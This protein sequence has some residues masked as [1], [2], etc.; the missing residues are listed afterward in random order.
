MSFVSTQTSTSRVGRY[1]GRAL[2]LTLA[3]GALATTQLTGTAYAA[4][5]VSGAQ[6]AGD[7]LFPNQGNGGYDV[8]HY[9]IKLKADFVTATANAAV[10]TSTVAT[11]TTIDAATT[12]APLSSYSLDFQGSTG[13][14]AASTYDVDT[15]TVNGAPAT[16]TRIEASSTT[17]ATADNHKL[18]ITPATPVEGS[19]TTVV[20]AHGAP[21][22]HFDTDGSAEGWNNTT[23]GATFVNQP[24]GS[25]TLFP[26]NNTPRDKATYTVSVDVPSTLKTSNYANAGGKPYPSAVAGNGELVSKT[27]NDDGSRT[28]WVWNE[29]KQMA[30]ELSMISIGRYDVYESDITLA[31]GRV[32]HEWSFI[33]PAIS[34]ANQNT[35]QVSRSQFKSLLD[36]YESKYGPYPGNS[37]GVV[38]D[39]VPSTINYALETQDRP[40]FPNSAGG[41][42][43]HEIMHQWWGDNVSP[44]DWNDITLNEGPA[45]YAP[46]QFAF[47]SSGTSNTT[48]EQ[49]VYATWNSAS[50]TSSTFTIAGAAMTNGNQLFGQQVYAKGAMSLE[51]LRTAIG[52]ADFETL[53]R[54]Y[55]LTYGGGQISGRRTAAFEALAESISGRDLTAF[56]QSWWFS[57]T[58][59]AWQVKFNLNVAGPTTQVNPG[60]ALTY[61]LSARNTGK[62]AMPAGGTV[63]T[64]DVGDVLDD[65]TIG[66]L[67]ANV[68]LDGSTLTWSVPATALAAT[69]TVD[70]PFTA[71]AA[72][73]GKTLK[74]VARASTLGG[75]CLSCTATTVVG[76]A[77]ISPAPVPTI[78]GGTPTVGVPLTA[79]TTGWADGTTFGYQWFLDGTPVPGATSATY[80]PASD[81]VGLPVTVRVTGTLAGFNPTTQTSAATAV[82]VRATMTTGTPTISGTPKIGQRLTVDRGTWQAGTVFTYQWRANGTNISGATGPSYV[83]AVASQVGQTIDVVVTGTRAGYT[84]ASKTSAA[85]TAVAAG[86]ALASTPT[87]TFTG[88]PKVGVP[89]APNYGSWDDGVTT[90][91]TWQANGTNIGGATTGSFTPTATQLGQTLTVTVTGTKAGITAVTKISAGSDAVV[92]GTQTLQPTPTITG[93]PRVGTAVTGVQGTWD[94]GTTKTNKWYADGVEIAG[95]TGTTY[96]PTVAQIG[97]VLTYEVTSTRSGYTT[98]TKTSEGKTIVGVQTLQ[99][100]P[101]IVGT[102]QVGHELTTS[103]TWDDGTSQ[104]FQWYADDVAIDGAVSPWFTPG[105]SEVGAAITVKVTST[106]PD[107]ETVSKTSDPTA[108][109]AKGD[110]ASTPVPTISGTAKVGRE[111]AAVPGTWDD[112]VEL[113]YQWLADG[114]PV[115]GAT[116]TTYTPGAGK[117]GAVVTVAV[118]GTKAGYD[119][120]TKTS[121]ATGPVAQGD[122]SSTPV[123]T[124]SGTPKV[125]ATLTA[126][127][128]DWDADTE[129]AY[130][131]L[132]DGTPVD[133]ATGTTYTPGPGKVGAV[134]TVAVTGTKTGYDPVTKTSEATSPVAQGDLVDTPVPTIT[135]TPKV[136]V[137]LTAVPGTWDDGVELTYQ[138]LADGT[139]VDGATGTTYTP[140]AG[141]VGAVVTVAVTGTKTGYDPVTRTSEATGPVA[142]GDLSSTPVPT[143]TGTP[144]VGATLTAHPGD[145]DADTELAYQWLAD[146]KPVSGATEETF[147]PA[148]GQLDA[149]ITVRVTGT[150]T[151]YEPVSRTSNATAA[152][153]L[154]DQTSTPTPAVMGT[155]Q[156]GGT[157]SIDRGSW[158]DGVVFDYA[159]SA[160]GQPIEGATDFFYHPSADD[161]GAVI[162]VSVTGRK[163]GYV[164]VTK[165]SEATSA[166]VAGELESTPTPVISGVTKVGETLTAAPGAWDDGTDLAYQWF[167]GED[168]IAGATGATYV[169][170]P[171]DLG[172]QLR[173]RVSGSKAGYVGVARSSDLTATIGLGDLVST[174]TPAITG[175]AK[176]GTVLKA[177]TGTWDD[178][179]T[180]SYQ[181]L[182]GSTPIS[183]AT[184]SSYPLVAADAGSKITLRVTGTKTGYSPA[185][186][187][188]LATAT[189]AKGKLATHPKPVIQGVAKVG[190][191][192]KVKPVKW[193]TGVKLT[194][195]WYAGSTPISGATKTSY[196]V[197][198]A[199]AGKKLHVVVTATKAGYT[200]VSASS[201]ATAKLKP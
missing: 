46:Y 159:W 77:P 167:A 188:S 3:A 158:D 118:T 152:V 180:L 9:D 139:P 98:V 79:D 89:F 35:T 199:Q 34:V 48:T 50:P 108:P 147:E 38:T 198:K 185:S 88:T 179:V 146:G 14:L 21:V 76:N 144:K 42:F 174:P 148:F 11:T 60:D 86:D 6:T 170:A 114:T 128:G 171:A 63:I 187:V 143:I 95:A 25:M 101:T 123:P 121:E 83:P 112:G 191:T 120:V 99:P 7:S 163:S 135:G 142:Q 56:F 13:N 145:W 172:K 115:D 105:A 94:T 189:V 5:A 197:K 40:F 1:V 52:A 195:K 168:A 178:G 33:D 96:T 126:H 175:A 136:G 69:A 192:L 166:V 31:S 32:L 106:K 131:W 22:I 68:T 122:L 200:T 107:Y 78:T 196:K 102:P 54:Q 116:G 132:A 20:T 129:L 104:A 51:A 111:L 17:A 10:G 169:V 47:E 62:I 41:S 109:V 44:T 181:W 113:A 87:P 201:A 173:V 124:I 84:T 183:G 73:T 55:Q 193:E 66:T 18:I 160:D 149:A 72:T 177:V 100:T 138:W 176:V 37:T 140:G 45:T 90:T 153:G 186:T 53:M 97:Q 70:V 154:G 141:K 39:V 23:D 182:R 29:T 8:S 12:G 43:Y 24:V 64:L 110:L 71:V 49:A 151:G 27:P 130:Q 125:G 82:G 119:P 59:P 127:P 150:K 161:L 162:T 36:F 156:V 117:V 74:A 2:A 4:D 165:T 58:K 67:P 16:F 92:A 75:T 93:T 190:R 61:T 194:Y 26:N 80:T 57:N 30:S 134:V 15:V 19:F 85:T 155:P 91:F 103:S 81:V 28:T 137:A 65:A 157:L 164:P 184:G 133:G